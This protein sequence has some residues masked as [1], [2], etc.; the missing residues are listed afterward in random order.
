MNIGILILYYKLFK[1]QGFFVVIS[2]IVFI[3]S[4]KMEMFVVYMY[5]YMYGILYQVSDLIYKLFFVW[6]IVIFW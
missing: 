1:G 6:I 5:I 3:I 2:K 4:F